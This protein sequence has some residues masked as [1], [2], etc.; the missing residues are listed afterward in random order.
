MVDG[1]VDIDDSDDDDGAFND[2]DD[3]LQG[4]FIYNFRM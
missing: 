1:F 4:F 3:N 2:S